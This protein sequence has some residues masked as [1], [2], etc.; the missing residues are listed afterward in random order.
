MK[1]IITIVTA[2]LFYFCAI[3][4]PKDQVSLVVMGHASTRDNAISSALRSAIEQS[5][6]AFISSQTRILNNV[7][8]S[9]EIVSVSSGNI[10]KY[11]ILSEMYDGKGYMVTVKAIVS[12][13]NL[14]SFMTKHGDN[15]KFDGDALANN[16]KLMRFRA[17]NTSKCLENLLFQLRSVSKKAFLFNVEQVENPIFSERRSCYYFPVTFS[18][19]S[20]SV[21]AEIANLI[22]STMNEISLSE[23]EIKDY[24]NFVGVTKVPENLSDMDIMNRLPHPMNFYRANT[25]NDKTKVILPGKQGGAIMALTDVMADCLYGV[26]VIGEGTSGLLEVDGM[27]QGWGYGESYPW[28][29]T[30]NGGQGVQYEGNWNDMNRVYD[31]IIKKERF[32]CRLGP[33][34]HYFVISPVWYDQD[35]SSHRI[36]DFGQVKYNFSKWRMK[37]KKNGELVYKITVLLSVTE[38]E[39][40]SFSGVSVKHESI[41]ERYKRNQKSK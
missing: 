20:N 18:C 21:S 14:S 2:S 11:T 8:V 29:I 17:D 40:S 3:A 30:Y 38:K 36:T 28:I 7:L 26:N 19:Y 13:S 1:K 41:L 10:K 24:E 12:L 34:A 33:S 6:G 5:Y 31:D 16:I 9:D 35:D 15:C 39:L 25:R 4:A 32:S 27:L 23:A 22:T 37:S